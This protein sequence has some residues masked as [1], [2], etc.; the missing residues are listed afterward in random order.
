MGSIW[1]HNTTHIMKLAPL[2]ASIG[3]AAI[4]IEEFNNLKEWGKGLGVNVEQGDSSDCVTTSGDWGSYMVCPSYMG[5]TGMCASG[6]NHDCGSNNY[7][8][9]WGKGIS[10]PSGTAMGGG[11]TSGKNHD[12][13]Q[14]GGSYSHQLLCC[15]FSGVSYQEDYEF[16]ATGDWGQTVTCP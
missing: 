1:L 4:P 2:L 5:A 8:A 13:T 12:C 9:D 3:V 7:G 11:C 14:G 16:Q 10:C 15:T 6:K